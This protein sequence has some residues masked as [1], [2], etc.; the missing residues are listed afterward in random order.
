MDVKRIAILLLPLILV[1]GGIGWQFGPGL[2]LASAGALLFVD[3][4]LLGRGEP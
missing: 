3:L 2:G 1:G 4:Y